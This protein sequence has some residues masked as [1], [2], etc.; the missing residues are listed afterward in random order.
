MQITLNLSS[1]SIHITQYTTWDFK[2]C[3]P[4]RKKKEKTQNSKWSE[5]KIKY[6][7]LIKECNKAEINKKNKP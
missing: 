6:S 4:M 1:N 7:Y 5:P 3:N 2:L